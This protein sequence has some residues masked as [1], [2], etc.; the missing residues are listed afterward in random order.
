M[1]RKV[2]RLT[3]DNLAELPGHCSTCVCWELDPV[4]RD[5]VRGREDQE[6][7]AWLAMMLRE[8]GTV[9]R[10]MR[11]DGAVVGHLL[12]AP[13]LYLPGGDGFAT[14]PVSNDAILLANGYVA[15]THRGQG[16]GR[17]LVQAMAKDLLKH[18]GISAVET[19][20]AQR[21]R[22]DVCVL[23]TDF[24]LAVGFKTHRPH[25]AYPR[26]RMDLRAAVTWREEFEAAAER[27]R[28][29]VKRPS[30]AAPIGQDTRTRL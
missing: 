2:E 30:R 9:G 21:P 19:F 10:V 25:A 1:T 20:G 14:A 23:P 12:W 27:L 4:R 7:A 3:L 6:K 16:L 15:P 8:W 18:G 26:L 24:L 11:V 17:V 28:G 5:Q 22:E 29:V 13:S